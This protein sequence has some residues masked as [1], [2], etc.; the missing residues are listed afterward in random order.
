[1]SDVTKNFKNNV[2]NQFKVNT[3]LRLH[4]KGWKVSVAGAILPPMSLF[5]DLQSENDNLMQIWFDVH[6]VSPSLNQNLK[7]GYVHGNDLKEM[8]KENKCRTG[9]EF[10]NE[11]KCLL[12]ERRCSNIPS[13]KKI[14]DSQWVNLEWKREAGEPELMIHHSH[15]GT[16]IMILQK[17]AEKMQWSKKK[18]H[19]DYHAGSNLVIRYPSHIRESSDLINSEPTRKDSTWLYLSSKADF[20]MTNLNTAFAQALN[21]H[22]RPLTITAN[23]TAN[24]ETVTQALGQVYYAPEGRQR[25]VFTPVVEEFYE[26]HSNHWNEVEITLKELH[27]QKVKFYNESQCVIRLH[28]KKE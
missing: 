12:D 24:K 11:I 19:Y 6:G 25:Y 18:K 1:M 22:S 13:G 15:P 10:M 7:K 5:P 9:I 14:L 28:F 21:L 3:Q 23:V 26:V 4:G 16:S 2:A 20:R 27:A 17:F 8:E